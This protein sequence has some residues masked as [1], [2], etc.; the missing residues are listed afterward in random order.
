MTLS[1][2]VDRYNLKD[3]ESISTSTSNNIVYDGKLLHKVKQLEE[4]DN[5]DRVITV[6][7]ISTIQSPDSSIVDDN[8]KIPYLSFPDE[9]PSFLELNSCFY[10]N[11]ELG[12]EVS[13][14]DEILIGDVSFIIR[15]I[16][17][18]Y[19]NLEGSKI[20]DQSSRSF[21][22]NSNNAQRVFNNNL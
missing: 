16:A 13:E 5:L 3:T 12:Y 21:F 15:Q 14:G 10:K 11:K 1:Y 17:L 20:E 18:N 8:T 19:H 4:N 6:I 22:R 7:N 2:E 9:G